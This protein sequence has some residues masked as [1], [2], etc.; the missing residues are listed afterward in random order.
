M[1]NNNACKQN[2]QQT[3]EKQPQKYSTLDHK[4]DDF[5][6]CNDDVDD[7]QPVKPPWIIR[8]QTIVPTINKTV[9]R[10]H[11]VLVSI[12]LCIPTNR[13]HL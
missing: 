11:K 6:D 13:D 10:Q 9:D 2:G 12:K 7:S 8:Q 4:L 1:N 3:A 5:E